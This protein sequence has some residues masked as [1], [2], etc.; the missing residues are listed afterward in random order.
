MVTIFYSYD[1]AAMLLAKISEI[2]TDPSFKH[3]NDV[4]KKITC[5]QVV[6]LCFGI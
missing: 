5:E 2:V 6:T 3:E 1:I 4:I